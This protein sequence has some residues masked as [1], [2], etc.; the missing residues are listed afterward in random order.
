MSSSKGPDPQCQH[1][2]KYEISSDGD[3]VPELPYPSRLGFFHIAEC[4]PIIHYV[5]LNKKL[6]RS[7]CDSLV[8]NGGYLV[9]SVLAG[10]SAANV[11][12]KLATLLPGDSHFP[13]IIQAGS[14]LK[15]T[16]QSVALPMPDIPGAKQAWEWLEAQAKPFYIDQ[17][18]M[19]PGQRM[20]P[21]ARKRAAKDSLVA[22]RHGQGFN[23]E[24]LRPA[25]NILTVQAAPP[26]ADTKD[27]ADSTLSL[28]D[29]TN[30]KKSSTK[31]KSDEKSSTKKSDE[32]KSEEKKVEKRK[33]GHKDSSEKAKKEKKE[34]QPAQITEVT[35][36]PEISSTKPRALKSSTVLLEPTGTDSEAPIKV[37]ETLATNT[38][39][40]PP[41][42]PTTGSL[43]TP[44]L[45][46]ESKSLIPSLNG[47]PTESPATI[48]DT[49]VAKM[50]TRTTPVPTTTVTALSRSWGWSEPFEFTTAPKKVPALSDYE[51]VAESRAPSQSTA[52]SLDMFLEGHLKLESP[53]KLLGP[54]DFKPMTSSI[55][56]GASSSPS[57]RSTP[58]QA[59]QHE[60]AGSNVHGKE[61]S[62]EKTKKDSGEKIKPK[63]SAGESMK[64]GS[65][66]I[67][68]PAKSPEKTSGEKSNASKKTDSPDLARSTKPSPDKISDQSKHN[69]HK[70]A[71][72]TGNH[73]PDKKA[74]SSDH[75]TH[76]KNSVTSSKEI[77]E[78]EVKVKSTST[79]P[80]SL[81]GLGKATLNLLEHKLNDAAEK[82]P[83][84]D[85][86]HEEKPSKP[87]EKPH[88]KPQG[89][90]HSEDSESGLVDPVEAHAP[91]AG[92]STQSPQEH[93][94]HV[95]PEDNGSVPPTV[96][97]ENTT[98][99]GYPELPG[100]SLPVDVPSQANLQ[101]QAEP[102]IQTYPPVQ[103][104][105][106]VPTGPIGPISPTQAGQSAVP[107]G[108]PEAGSF[109]Q[110]NTSIQAV[111]QSG[112]GHDPSSQLSSQGGGVPTSY[113]AVSVPVS[114]AANSAAS[115]G[116]TGAKINPLQPWEKS[117][118][119]SPSKGS[120]AGADPDV[121]HHDHKM[122]HTPKRAHCTNLED[123]KGHG[124]PGRGSHSHQPSSKRPQASKRPYGGVVAGSVVAGV[125]VGATLTSLA[126]NS[127]SD[128]ESGSRSDRDSN[129]SDANGDDH[130]SSSEGEDGVEPES[131]GDESSHEATESEHGQSDDDDH[132]NA[133][134]S[135]SDEDQESD[136]SVQ[137]SDNENSPDSDD[138]SSNGG[139]DHEAE[140]DDDDDDDSGMG[141]SSESDGSGDESAGEV[142]EGEDDQSES[143]PSDDEGEVSDDATPAEDTSDS[144]GNASSDEDQDDHSSGGEDNSS[145]EE[146]DD[147]DDDDEGTEQDGSSNGDGSEPDAEDFSNNGDSSDED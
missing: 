118:H 89:H 75:S 34:K 90:G 24:G 112:W 63:K 95:D 15:D 142:E 145:G 72:G 35:A 40:L 127:G 45:A 125:A 136:A 83:K 60:L 43:S 16:S 124:K 134:E 31:K 123:Q 105:A 69:P 50:G 46:A 21:L 97:G 108:M 144:D 54:G 86:V 62:I 2:D 12:A 141:A 147:D 99:L 18:H 131:D 25:S 70:Y 9:W 19:V 107:Y 71:P 102:L 80:G 1:P 110:S 87:H 139:S 82:K 79:G 47:A 55:S 116:E 44:T 67:S 128:D 96:P 23:L 122:P 49:K 114:A 3:P 26:V 41:S 13:P 115:V 14:E 132:S 109:V 137:P 138:D 56:G 135:D 100:T 11:V 73:R 77:H 64:S 78:K 113:P 103:T 133:E 36:L 130:E 8:P 57:K 17:L 48:G 37:R 27:L 93:Q 91:Q 126:G 30:S 51:R 84:K 117:S 120:G 52:K 42:L 22:L 58:L 5:D 88:E 66:E 68:K 76:S 65:S 121:R 92:Q 106:P 111:G 143:Q 85:K 98:Q 20:S 81:S 39:Q 74:M 29:K 33:S 4:G 59:T 61:S 28:K 38:V 101:D 32:K 140:D 119:H 6:C 129:H 146:E 94:L 10:T 53:R 7:C 104:D